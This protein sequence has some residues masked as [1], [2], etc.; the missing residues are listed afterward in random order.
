M[1]KTIFTVSEVNQ[2]FARA[3]RAVGSGHVIITHRGEPSLVLMSYK[4]YK[5][6]NRKAPSLMDRLHVAGVEDI[7]FDLAALPDGSV[8]PAT[9]D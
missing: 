8:K 1:T 7:D 4:S 5:A 3:Q 6:R 2:D 9:F